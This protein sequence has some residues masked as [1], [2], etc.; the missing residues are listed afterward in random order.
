MK[1]LL[2]L[3][4][5]RATAREL[6]LEELQEALEKLQ[7]IVAEREESESEAR[8][9]EKEKQEKFDAY[10]EMLLADGIDPEELLVSLAGAPKKAKREPRLA[11][12]KFD[13]DG[14]DRTWTGQGRMP[15]SLKE[16][17]VNEGKSLDD[18]LI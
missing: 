15:A 9:A 8:Q 16:A 1:T 6:S 2:N 7:T 11:K 10:M 12:Y 5:L 17:I 4:S 14:E 3:R 13:V 18:F